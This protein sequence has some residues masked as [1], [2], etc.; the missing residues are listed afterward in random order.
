MK[1]N[2]IYDNCL[3][4]SHLNNCS[5]YIINTYYTI[6]SKALPI[7]GKVSDICENKW[8]I[9]VYLSAKIVTLRV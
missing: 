3:W 7:M 1:I 2:L 8:I 5:S 9:F 6:S 4:P